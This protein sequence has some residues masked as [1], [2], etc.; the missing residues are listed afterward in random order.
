MS[1]RRDEP[2]ARRLL[3]IY[4]RDHLGGAAAGVALARRA[5]RANVGSEFAPLLADIEREISDDRRCLRLI[6]RRLGV[7][8]SRLKQALGVAAE[9][10]GRLKSNGRIIHYSPSA[11]VLELEALMGA[12]TMKRALWVALQVIASGYHALDRNELDRLARRAHDQ[13]ARLADAHE[14]AARIAFDGTTR[15]AV[16]SRG[17]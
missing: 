6:M 4:L 5:R 16:S 14:R 10:A 13:L 2:D 9:L 3:G 12:V 8:E 15:F 7:S 17:Y 11:R 1:Q